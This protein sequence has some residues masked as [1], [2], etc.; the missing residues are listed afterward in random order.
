MNT[1]QRFVPHIGP[2]SQR[3]ILTFGMACAIASCSIIE[4]RPPS[5]VIEPQIDL[6][7]PIER[8]AD[9]GS[10]IVLRP[11]SDQTRDGRQILVR[12]NDSSLQ[13]LPQYLWIEKVP[14]MLR[15]IMLDSFRYAGP[16][17]DA[18]PGGPAD[19]ILHST[20][21][22]FEAVDL[23]NGNVDVDIQLYLRL[24]EQRSG[25]PTLSRTLRVERAST[26]RDPGDLITAFELAMEDLLVE[27]NN[28]LVEGAALTD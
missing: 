21:R 20:L 8:S 12:R 27:L 17:N 26:G 15:S 24:I 9:Y 13:V 25:R 18:A 28:W 14:D 22:R 2:W 7:E 10:I 16:F 1:I 19:W 6:P 5:R 11:E 23:G 4:P 3:I